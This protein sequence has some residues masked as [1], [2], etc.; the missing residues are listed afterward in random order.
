MKILRGY[1][2]RQG[3]V[4]GAGLY[5]ALHPTAPWIESRGHAHRWGPGQYD[6][7]SAWAKLFGDRIVL[8]YQEVRRCDLC[9]RPG[10]RHVHDGL[11]TCAT[12][13]PRC[14]HCL[15]IGLDQALAH[16]APAL[17]SAVRRALQR[18]LLASSTPRT[19][20]KRTA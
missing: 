5:Y 13:E 1:L 6:E 4:K 19:D 3:H 17:A 10:L 8:V 20:A 15:A 16:T 18:G 12:C 11:A 9:K 7:A 2:A 14:P